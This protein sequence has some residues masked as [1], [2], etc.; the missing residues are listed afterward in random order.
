MVAMRAE[1]HTSTGLGATR[2]A[3]FQIALDPTIEIVPTMV[4]Y[5]GQLVPATDLYALTFV[6]K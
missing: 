3:E 2:S 1:G 6:P 5:H 4:S